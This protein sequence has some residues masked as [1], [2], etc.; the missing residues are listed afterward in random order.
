MNTQSRTVTLISSASQADV[1]AFL[2]NPE[3]LPLWANEFCKEIRED[4]DGWVISNSE[5][6]LFF[7]INACEGKGIIDMKAG[8]SYDKMCLLPVRVLSTASGSITSF[9]FNQ[10]SEVSI[11]KYESDFRTFVRDVNALRDRFGAG[12]VR[13]PDVRLHPMYNG[14][15]VADLKSSAEFYVKHFGFEILF[16][17]GFYLQLINPRNGSQIGL[18]LP[19]ES[20]EENMKPFC[21]VVTGVGCWIS[22]DVSNVDAE[23]DRLQ[24]AGLEIVHSLK[25]QPWGERSFAVRDPNGIQIHLGQ[26]I[27]PSEEFKGCFRETSLSGII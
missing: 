5:G 24:E 14:L 11:E 13:A 1:F 6:E 22:L 2:S 26:R 21:H 9:T 19:Q 20:T 8:P 3:T 17:G 25:D 4:P 7:E 15:I 18:M 23:H 16:E 27:E 12:S 10:G